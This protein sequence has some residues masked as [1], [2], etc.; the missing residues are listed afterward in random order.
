MKAFKMNIHHL[1]IFGFTLAISLS[2]CKPGGE[3]KSSKARK[4]DSVIV[5]NSNVEGAGRSLEIEMIKGK[6][7]NH[8]TFAL[9]IEDTNGKY[10]Q[11]IFV[12]K[13]I[14]QGIFEHGDKSGG[15]WKPGEVRRPSALPYWAHKRGIKNEYGSFEPTPASKV[16]DAYSGATPAGSFKLST[17]T[18]NRVQGKVKLMMEINQPWD[19]NEYWTNV[20]YPNDADYQASCQPAVVYSAVIDLAD[21]GSKVELKPI[22]HSHYSGKNGDLDADLS[23]ITSALYIADKISVVVK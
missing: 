20:L 16:P 18:D 9:W 23:S 11:T 17:R 12:T 2:A 10:L 1:L 4:Q 5:I 19:W 6:A 7:H 3:G 22:G 8:P 14:G 15:A 13:A 21:T